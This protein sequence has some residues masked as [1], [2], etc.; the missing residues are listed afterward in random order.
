MCITNAYKELTVDWAAVQKD[1]QGALKFNMCLPQFKV[2]QFILYNITFIT[3]KSCVCAI[4][5]ALNVEEVCA[6]NSCVFP[7]LESGALQAVCVRKLSLWA[8]EFYG[9]FLDVGITGLLYKGAW[10]HSPIS[11]VVVPTHDCCTYPWLCIWR[12]DF[13]ANLDCKDT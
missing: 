13:P 10:S 8:L 7:H 4:H 11:A 12:M 9:H 2:Y 5:T 1:L 6:L 3:V